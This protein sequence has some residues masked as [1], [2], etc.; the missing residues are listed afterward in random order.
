M[1]RVGSSRRAVILMALL[2]LLISQEQHRLTPEQQKRLPPKLAALFDDYT[3][4]W[5]IE[6][7]ESAHWVTWGSSSSLEAALQVRDKI[8]A[9]NG[10]REVLIW[11]EP[12]PRDL[13]VDQ[14][15]Q[16]RSAQ[17]VH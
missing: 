10:P 4:G 12:L 3:L 8:L 9:E 11:H 14:V 13:T 1:D 2:P 17:T 6:G 15:A 5:L 16:I 7:D